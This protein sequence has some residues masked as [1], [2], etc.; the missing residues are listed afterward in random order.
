[1][2]RRQKIAEEDARLFREAV[3]QVRPLACT[4]DAALR[5]P[6]TPAEPRQFL[7]DEANVTHELLSHD[8][9]P[10]TTEFGD[11]LLY[12]KSGQSSQLLRRLRRGHFSIRAEIDLH[13]MTASVAREAIRAF[14]DDCRRE[15][16][17]C[18]RIIHG[19]GLRSR[20]RGP[21]LKRLT[22]SMLARRCDVLAYASARPAQGG[23][24]AVIVLLQPL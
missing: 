14:L 1:M 9:D 3:G 17:Y 19:K 2:P 8:V 22:Q 4:A 13:Q 20:A 7:E 24:G 11:E 6:G 23:T 21:V 15:R 16:E 18:V 5:Y 10:A 12:L